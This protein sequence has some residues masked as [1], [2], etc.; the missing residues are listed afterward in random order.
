[1]KKN[2]SIGL[3]LCL[4]LL[5]FCA[6]A[7]GNTYNVD[8]P[9]IHLNGTFTL[10]VGSSFGIYDSTAALGRYGGL[11]GTYNIAWTSVHFNV[12]PEFAEI[13]FAWDSVFTGY[14]VTPAYV[15]RE[16]PWTSAS[17]AWGDLMTKGVS[18]AVFI[19]VVPEPATIGILGAG[20]LS[21]GLLR[22][23]KSK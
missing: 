12:Q 20:V 16:T 19:T 18:D 5:P 22:N 3:L 13:Q 15:G 7:S 4:L 14:A 21:L 23:R 11:D 9:A 10:N 6:G 2:F 8:W 17:D 1:M